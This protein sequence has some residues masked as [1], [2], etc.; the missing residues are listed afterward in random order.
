MHSDSSKLHRER[1]RRRT[2]SSP[3]CRITLHR[4]DEQTL[5]DGRVR[6]FLLLG[7]RIN[8][9]YNSMGLSRATETVLANDR[10][11]ADLDRVRRQI[12]TSTDIET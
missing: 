6:N 4:D 7:L 12:R 2:T 5:R 11:P 10:L 3:T 8:M 9:L 1:L